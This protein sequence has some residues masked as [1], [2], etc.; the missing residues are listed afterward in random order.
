MEEKVQKEFDHV[1]GSFAKSYRRSFAAVKKQFA[2]LIEEK[3][4]L[5]KHLLYDRHNGCLE[6]SFENAQ[7]GCDYAGFGY[8][9]ETGYS[10]EYGF[11]C[12]WR[13]EKGYRAAF[14]KSLKTAYDRFC[15][16][17]QPTV[18]HLI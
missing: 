10:S 9:P 17:C 16:N 14:S 4:A 3:P 13:D 18:S 5:L 11:F 6:F 12:T 2:A 7:D 8:S 15:K 1:F